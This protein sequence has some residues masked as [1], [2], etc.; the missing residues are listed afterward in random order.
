MDPEKSS[1]FTQTEKICS[2]GIRKSVNI[3]HSHCE[4]N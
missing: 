4:Q 3:M 1:A 2:F